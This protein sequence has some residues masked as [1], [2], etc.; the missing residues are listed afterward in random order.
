M[1]STNVSSTGVRGPIRIAQCDCP[2]TIH[3]GQVTSP[4]TGR[5][6]HATGKG[7]I[8]SLTE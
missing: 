8:C 6:N 2:L 4:I 1:K 5:Y 7:H 3:S